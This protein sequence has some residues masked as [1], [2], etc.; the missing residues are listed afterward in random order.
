[1]GG[2]D[3]KNAGNCQR[4]TRDSPPQLRKLQARK[5]FGG[6]EPNAG[7]DNKRNPTSANVFVV[8][9]L[10]ATINSDR[11]D[12]T[13]QHGRLPDVTEVEAKRGIRIERTASTTSAPLLPG[14]CQGGTGGTQGRKGVRRR[15]TDLVF[16]GRH[17]R[18]LRVQLGARHL[19]D[20]RV[21][22]RLTEY[23]AS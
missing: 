14:C 13:R 20:D 19:V 16:G 4:A 23:L 10:R 17:E 12:S 1:M 8:F 5:D 6:D 22:A 15:P 9:G 3:Q 11:S 2:D 7:D 21:D 18:H